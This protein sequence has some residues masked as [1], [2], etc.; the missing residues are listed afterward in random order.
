MLSPAPVCS[1]NFYP[2]GFMFTKAIVKTPGESMRNGLSRSGLGQPDFSLALMQHQNYIRALEACGL[3]V[4]VLEADEALPDAVFVEDTAV[5]FEDCAV[6]TRPGAPTRRQE[7]EAVEAE[8]RKH[9]SRLEFISGDGLLDGGDVM[10]IGG[11]FYIGLSSR[12]NQKGADQLARIAGSYAYRSVQ[13]PLGTMLHL[14]TG[15][16]H[17]TANYLLVTGEFVGKDVFREYDQIIVP[18]DEA[19]AANSLWINGCVL[20]PAGFPRTRAKIDALGLP[21]LEVDVSEYRKLDGGLSC[22]SLRF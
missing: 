15:V 8:L 21:T 1:G 19:Y 22:L 6:V 11:T 4:I 18:Q 7:T 5:V 13:V 2:H 16:N 17:L 14:K 3:E 12:T 10:C 9:V 20:V